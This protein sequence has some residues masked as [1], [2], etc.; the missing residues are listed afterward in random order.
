MDSGASTYGHC[1]FALSWHIERGEDGPIDLSGFNV[2]IVGSWFRDGEPWHVYLYLDERASPEQ[3]TALEGIF[4]G[5]RGGTT[6]RN[7]AG[8][9]DEVYGVIPARIDLDHTRGRERFSIEHAVTVGADLPVETD[10]DVTCGIPGHVQPG[11]ELTAKLMEVTTPE[12]S[13]RLEGQ[14]AF[15]ATFD[16]RSDDA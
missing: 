3:R 8:A 7:F 1:D 14:C 6:L 15:V 9:F 5:R 12:L 11:Q 16:Y 10:L 13:W 2:V 4:L